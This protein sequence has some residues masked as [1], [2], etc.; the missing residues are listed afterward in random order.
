MEALRLTASWPVPTVAAAVVRPDGSTATIGDSDHEFRLASISKTI[1]AWTV[2]VG[3]EEGI[4]A[5]AD[6]VGQPGCT[7]RHLLAHAGGYPFDGPDPIARPGTRR[8]YSNTGIE[9]A[10]EHLA[11]SAG[12]VFADY[13]AEAVL[14]PLGMHR[15]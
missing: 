5:L 6:A 4:V 11:A 2:L 12:I 9:L 15:T 8:I 7:L 14:G 3:V 10:A 13:L 1:T